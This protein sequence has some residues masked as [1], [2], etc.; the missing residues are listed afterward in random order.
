MLAAHLKRVGFV[1][2]YARDPAV[3]QAIRNYLAIA[4]RARGV[5][6]MLRGPGFH[7]GLGSDA[8]LGQE[9]ASSLLGSHDPGD[10]AAL[11]DLLQE[12]G[13]EGFSGLGLVLQPLRQILRAVTQPGEAGPEPHPAVVRGYGGEGLGALS[14]LIG[15]QLRRPPGAGSRPSLATLLD[16]YRDE[17]TRYLHPSR[18]RPLANLIE[19]L[20]AGDP[21]AA[22]DLHDA[23]EYHSG[24]ELPTNTARMA[25]HAYNHVGSA[26]HVADAMHTLLRHTI[27]PALWQ[28]G[29]T[30]QLPQ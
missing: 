15:R 28:Y 5:P 19:Q 16:D 14:G 18:S 11:I 4:L 2:K 13:A 23:A 30:G 26:S 7:Q 9:M 3:D 27:H 12:H 22:V 10:L 8:P 21:M 25:S 6:G 17:T 1:K 29:E 24:S 20:H